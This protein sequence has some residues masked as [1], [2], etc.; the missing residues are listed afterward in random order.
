MSSWEAIATNIGLAFANGG[1]RAL[2]WGFFIV[3]P[4]ILC[5]VA[6]LA[7]LASVQ[8]IAGAQYHWT[9]FLAPPEWR[10]SVTWLQGWITW[11]SWISLLAGMANIGANVVVTIV[12]A[13][14]GG[15]VSKDWHVVLIMYA[16][17][18]VYGLI[19]NYAWW[20]VPYIEVMSGMLHIVLWVVFV[21][22][23]VGMADKHSAEW[24][25]FDKGS[26]SGWDN[27]F[28]EFNLG[29]ILVTWGFVGRWFSLYCR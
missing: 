28:V 12:Q 20:T 24:V 21:A 6:S 1:P 4:G 17:L 15:Y 14:Y 7:E 19:N 18:V 8:P 11:F 29:I 16:L 9:H 23:L 10:R 22:V 2:I 13:Q 27:D 26:S 3:I 25:F 5:Q